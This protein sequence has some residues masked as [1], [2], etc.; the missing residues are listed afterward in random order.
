MTSI[1]DQNLL[2][3]VQANS[4]EISSNPVNAP[5]LYASASAFSYDWFVLS[6]SNTSTNSV[7][8]TRMSNADTD[9][10]TDAGYATGSN[11]ESRVER[12]IQFILPQA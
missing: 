7:A 5:T 3:S 1:N 11:M 12:I 2:S 10:Q 8:N 6:D 9:H 4:A